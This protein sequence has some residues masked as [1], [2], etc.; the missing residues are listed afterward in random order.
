VD[1]EHK[2]AHVRAIVYGCLHDAPHA[3][4]LAVGMSVPIQHDSGA[5]SRQ[6]AVSGAACPQQTTHDDLACIGGD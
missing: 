1:E 4:H 6:A 5:L 3:T 2:A